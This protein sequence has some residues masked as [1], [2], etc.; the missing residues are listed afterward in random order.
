MK[1][2]VIIEPAKT[3]RCPLARQSFGRDSARVLWEKYQGC[4]RFNPHSVISGMAIN[5]R[6]DDQATGI[7]AR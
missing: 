5:P 1:H 4:Q 6:L 3:D 7:G 2:L